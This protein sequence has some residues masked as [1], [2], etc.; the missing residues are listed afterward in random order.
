MIH[1]S[2]SEW[3]TWFSKWYEHTIVVVVVVESYEFKTIRIALIVNYLYFYTNLRND[4]ENNWETMGFLCTKT[5]H[6][7][8][9]YNIYLNTLWFSKYQ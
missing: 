5:L 3:R 1:K 4:D 6:V 8:T 9:G 7:V 2:W